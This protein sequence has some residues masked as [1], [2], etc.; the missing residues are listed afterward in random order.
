MNVQTTKRPD[1]FCYACEGYGY[2]DIRTVD[3]VPYGSGDVPMYGSEREP[4]P[5]CAEKHRCPQC[6]GEMVDEDDMSTCEAC[7]HVIDW[8]HDA[9]HEHDPH[10]NEP[11]SDYWNDR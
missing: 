11:D 4:C 6:G 9:Q 10:D 3:W 8:A 1:G 5:E 2:W 7:G